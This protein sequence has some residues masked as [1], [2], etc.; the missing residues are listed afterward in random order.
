MNTN[1]DHD[2]PP[3]VIKRVESMDLTSS[4]NSMLFSW[5]E[6][7]SKQECVVQ[8]VAIVASRLD[9]TCDLQ[10][11]GDFCEAAATY[12][13]FFEPEAKQQIKDA[14]LRFG[15]DASIA[16]QYFNGLRYNQ[17]DVRTHLKGEIKED[18]SFNR[19]RRDAA[20]WHYYLYLASLK[21]PD[22]YVALA[23]KLADT[24]DGNDATN[25]IKSLA[26]VKTKQTKNILLKYKE[27][28]R[29]SDGPVGPGPTIAET[30]E[31]LLPT[32]PEYDS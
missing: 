32:F 7:N 9:N 6:E 28:E 23:E 18:W 19:P 24:K 3:E 27:D 17:I 2:C 16:I 29:H 26:D 11:I 14:Y 1:D 13:K 31:A 8:C 21:S 5:I 22:A 10:V 15:Y 4:D 12:A 20:T 30:V 25:L